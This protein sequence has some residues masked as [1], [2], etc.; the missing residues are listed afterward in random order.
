[1]VRRPTWRASAWLCAA[2]CLRVTRARMSIRVTLNSGTHRW[3][4]S[5]RCSV[6]RKTEMSATEDESKE[7]DAGWDDEEASAPSAAD[8]DEAWDSVA[9]SASLA[10][11]PSVPPETDEVDGGWD[12]APS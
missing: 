5:P 12:D 11:A 10:A 9:S 7:L 6:T 4:R 2:R 8:V 1:M 3:E